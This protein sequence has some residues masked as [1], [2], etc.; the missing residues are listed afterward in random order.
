MEVKEGRFHATVRRRLNVSLLPSTVDALTQLALKF[1]VPRGYLIDRMTDA[2][3]RQV[4]AGA[5]HCVDGRPCP[6]KEVW[7][8]GAL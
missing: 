1:S 4:Q 5:R 6:F 2:L 3:R 7:T 8:D